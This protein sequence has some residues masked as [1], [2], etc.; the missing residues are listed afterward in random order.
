MIDDTYFVPAQPGHF[1]L[2]YENGTRRQAV[3]AWLVTSGVV[4][5]ATNRKVLL[6][7][8]PLL[9]PDGHVE[10]G[11][12]HWA[13]LDDWAEHAQREDAR[14]FKPGDP[15]HNAEVFFERFGDDLFIL[16]GGGELFGESKSGGSAGSHE[17]HDVVRFLTQHG[18]G[19][20][21]AV[22]TTGVILWRLIAEGRVMVEE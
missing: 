13:T 19:M 18:L 22:N 11:G 12:E 3:V 14:I 1:V 7:G 5:P 21:D 16:N 20:R 6:P 10:S 8:H 2:N 4:R 9:F 17:L 15:V